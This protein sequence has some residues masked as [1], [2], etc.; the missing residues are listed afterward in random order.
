M[1]SRRGIAVDVHLQNVYLRE[2]EK[3]CKLALGAHKQVDLA[4]L[5]Y[6]GV[7]EEYMELR[8]HLPESP[9]DIEQVYAM[10]DLMDRQADVRP[11]CIKDS[12]AYKQEL[13]RHVHSLLT[14]AGNIS[15]LL[16]PTK[17]R[18]DRNESNEDYRARCKQTSDRG[19]DLRRSLNI[20][21]QHPL[22][23]RT[24]RNN[25]EHFDERLDSWVRISENHNVIELVGPA[26]AV[27]GADVGDVIAYDP[28]TGVYF[29]RGDEFSVQTLVI[30]VEQLL[31]KVKNTLERD[32][33]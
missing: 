31:P 18:R 33:H 3:H 12:E 28:A 22:K 9:L 11:K 21:E 1:S 25:L 19:D 17:P 2:L 32:D 10:F 23:D 24:L 13:L 27:A 7:V 30:A 6:K 5:A 8:P 14:Q 16:W 26:S 20:P 15:K 29:F 4:N